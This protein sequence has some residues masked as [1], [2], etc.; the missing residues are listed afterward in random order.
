MLSHLENVFNEVRHFLLKD[1]LN[2][3]NSL[4]KNPKGDT[5]KEFDLKAEKIFVNY[6]KKNFLNVEIISEESGKIK[7]SENPDYLIILDPVDGSKNFSEKIEWTGFSVAVLDYGPILL[8]NVKFAFVGNIFTGSFYKTEKNKGTFFNNEKIFS[9]LETELSKSSVVIAQ[10]PEKLERIISLMKKIKHTRRLG[11]VSLE[12][13]NVATGGFDSFVDIMD[14]CTPENFSASYLILK[15]AGGVLTDNLGNE[16][17]ELNM[18]TGYN[19]VASGNKKLHD[20]II[21]VIK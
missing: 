16:L 11:S 8:K 10:K 15:E 3:K 7:I 5:T 13:S 4:G 21:S 19:I 6:C 18:T 14:K 2:M 1:G 9:S 12:I 20:K 17:D